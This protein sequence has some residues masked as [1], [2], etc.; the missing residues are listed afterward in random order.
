[1][2]YIHQLMNMKKDRYLTNGVRKKIV[3]IVA[4]SLGVVGQSRVASILQEALS[5]RFLPVVVGYASKMSPRSH[6]EGAVLELPW[7]GDSRWKR[8][9]VYPLRIILFIFAVLYLQPIIIV[10]Q[11]DTGGALAYFGAVFVGKTKSIWSVHESRVARSTQGFMST[12]VYRA[13]KRCDYVH[14]IC[15]GLQQQYND[16]HNG[17]FVIHTPPNNYD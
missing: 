13:A 1:M 17:Y 4:P 12:M 10:G 3:F 5:V 11:G 15:H 7:G 14:F 9:L 2:H 16:I 8:V 6:F